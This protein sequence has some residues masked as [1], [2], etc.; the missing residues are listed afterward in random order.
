[1]L[2]KA[3]LKKLLGRKGKDGRPQG[4]RRR[5]H[6]Q[7]RLPPSGRTTITVASK[8]WLK[9][10]TS[11]QPAIGRVMDSFRRQPPPLRRRSD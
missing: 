2:G 7:A 1:M 4:R 11:R 8:S 3:K 6:L 5:S 10:K 9:I